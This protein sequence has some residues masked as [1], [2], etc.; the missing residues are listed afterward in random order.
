MRRVRAN[1]AS[2]GD[3]GVRLRGASARAADLAQHEREEQ[4][5]HPDLEHADRRTGERPRQLGAERERGEGHRAE[6]P[7]Q[8]AFAAFERERQQQSERRHHQR[9]GVAFGA[10]AEHQD[11]AH[12]EADQEEALPTRVDA[13]VHEHAEQQRRD[14]EAR[15]QREARRDA[16]RDAEGKP[17]TVASNASVAELARIQEQDPEG[18]DKAKKYL[19]NR[20]T[21][22]AGRG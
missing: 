15:A 17:G 9:V 18:Y 11:V 3:L 7:R 16:D 22:G 19:T 14:G 6:Q 10:R 2:A 8:P 5:A 4:Q 21:G 20:H 1:S 12:R 13:A